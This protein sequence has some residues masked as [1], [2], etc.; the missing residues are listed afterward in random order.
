MRASTK[1]F[2]IVLLALVALN[3]VHTRVYYGFDSG[4]KT[5]ITDSD[6]V[7]E[8]GTSGTSIVYL[9]AT[10][11]AVLVDS[12][13][14]T[15][16][17]NDYNITHGVYASGATPDDVNAVDSNFFIVDAAGS[18]ATAEVYYPSAYNLLG[19]TTLLSGSVGD[20]ASDN[21]VYMSFRS[22][23]SG[24]PD[25]E[26]PVDSDASDV[27]SS[28]DKGFSSGFAS[29]Q[30]GPDAA[31]DELREQYFGGLVEDYVDLDTS[32]VDSTSDQGSL[33]NFNNMKSIGSGYS[34]LSE[35]VTSV[36][37]AGS[38]ESWS[39]TGASSHSFQ[40]NLQN[41]ANNYRLL[42]VG[43]SWE[44]AEATASATVTFDGVAMTE[45]ATITVGAGIG[46]EY[47]GFAGMWYLNED[48]L[49]T[50]TGNKQVI[51][52]ASEAITREIY[53]TVAEYTGVAQDPL[54][55]YSTHSR[56]V[57]GNT[58]VTLTAADDGSVVVAVGVQGG[59]NSWAN[60]NNL[61]NLQDALLTSFGGA[62]GHHLDASSG[63]ITV[64][65]N[66][67]GTREAMVGA[68]WSAT[69]DYQIDQEVQW[70]SPASYLQGAEL[71]MSVG[72]HMGNEEL[73]VQ[74]W[75][76]SSSQWVTLGNLT[77]NAWNN[78]TIG[79]YLT[80]SDF[81]IRYRTFD[82]AGDSTLDTWQIDAAFIRLLGSGIREDPVDNDTSDVDSSPDKG[83][84]SSFASQ[85]AGP[86]S[87]YD[88]LT[89]TWKYNITQV[90][91]ESFEGTW[92]PTGWSSTGNWNRE[93]DQ[94]YQG[95]YS[96]DFDGS[97]FG[98][99]SGYLYTP[100]MD[101]SDASAIYVSFRFRDHLLD[102]ND[103]LLQYY[104]GTQWDT[105]QDMDGYTEDTWIYWEQN[106]TDSQ[107]FKN[108][109]QVRFY[110]LTVSTGEAIWVDVVSITK[111]VKNCELNLEVQWTNVDYQLPYE[112]LCI[113]TGATGAENIMVQVWN[114]SSSSW[115]TLLGD[116]TAG[117]WNNVS[118][119]EWL[120]S[121]IFT[122][123][124]LGG[125][126][127]GDA[128]QDAWQIDVA[129][130]KVWANETAQ[131]SLDLEFQWMGA[132]FWEQNEELCIYGGTMGAEDILVDVWYN[133]TWINLFADLA[134]GW[135]NVSI[136]SY[137]DSST[138]TIRARGGSEASDALRE[139]WQVDVSMIHVWGPEY[140][141]EVELL[142]DSNL[143]EWPQIEWTTDSA[144]TNES[145]RV[146]L[147]LYDYSSG[148]YPTAGDGYMGYT[149]VT[150]DVDETRSQIISSNPENYRNGTGWWRVRLTGRRYTQFDL[151]L[152]YAALN[153]TYYVGYTAQT[154]FIFTDITDNQSPNLNFTVVTHNSIENV[155][156][157][158]QVWNYTTSSYATSG[159]G[160]VSYTS[161]G[162][163]VVNW[164]NITSNAQ[165]CLNVPEA[166]IRVTGILATTDGFQQITNL[167]RLRQEESIQL[168]DYALRVTNNGASAYQVRLSM[169][170]SSN[171][172][173]LINCTIYF[174]PGEQQLQVIDGAF[175]QTEGTWATI[176]A[177]SSLDLLIEASS[178]SQ[179][180][181]SVI[182][183]ELT[184]MEQGTS[185][186]TKLPV[187]ITVH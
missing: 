93:A 36:S 178:V 120:T 177:A 12:H 8:E 151:N 53:V 115:D 19:N 75:N 187:R 70:T 158:I 56:D 154:E 41:G 105:I 169:V 180:S 109:F 4:A 139:T 68:V 94:A 24:N 29:Q 80:G 170:S 185:T 69:T 10:S 166:R 72:S 108:N 55:D 34:V 122:I 121:D 172:A 25:V 155:S 167:V 152:D 149:V 27:D 173:R 143:Y 144:W 104:D 134:A 101:C 82:E 87:V 89:E 20:V 3:E 31:Y 28:P 33:A 81:T 145:V 92:P 181:A 77:A 148:S 102:V 11:A 179:E 161:T 74:F 119:S 157:T 66:N 176:P 175:T 1:K 164:L 85:Q 2:I 126:E 30:A 100:S 140:T 61:N 58:A 51:V 106:V 91:A 49:P 129:L 142:G 63:D 156:V 150:A 7:L 47:S 79:A 98:G 124:Y 45:V 60:T 153:T 118:I 23:L 18:S 132:D 130:I 59:G 71:A 163:N 32:N 44:D 5:S 113:Y 186:Y 141:A 78:Y 96:A 26:D 67:L 35:T 17:P 182:D 127:T 165:T 147:Q 135:N 174:R 54:D 99:V 22:Y 84:H 116:L 117:S 65:W 133:G 46:T 37:L 136:A 107:Y 131:Y 83:T 73:T 138:F 9:N 162:T 123:R 112:E 48:Q 160:Y 184:A 110:A 95:T 42:V 39:S 21:G 114:M 97:S 171:V 6:I 159:Q 125:T 86:D 64:G 38:A 128:T 88:T 137:L 62:L 76:A 14:T 52:T 111:E 50:T 43:V 103:F 146:Q 16:Y 168:H 15:F 40:Y 183:A 90:N 13:S 57:S